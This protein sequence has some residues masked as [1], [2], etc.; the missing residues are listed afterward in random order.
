MARLRTAHARILFW[1][2]A[3][4]V[5]EGSALGEDFWLKKDYTQWSDEEIRKL[6]TLE[7]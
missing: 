4:M 5:M 7:L 1:C 2:F 3:L 6:M